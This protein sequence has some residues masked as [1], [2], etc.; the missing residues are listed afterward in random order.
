MDFRRPLPTVA[1]LMK[2]V[3]RGPP[4][5]PALHDDFD[6]GV[7]VVGALADQPAGAVPTAVR[8]LP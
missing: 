4:F 6:T 3:A 8:V 1:H 7:R 2:L 5:A